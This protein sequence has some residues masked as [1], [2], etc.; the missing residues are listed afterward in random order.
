M[1]LKTACLIAIFFSLFGID[2]HFI[3]ETK[4]LNKIYKV[5]ER[6]P[7][8]GWIFYDKGNKTG[9]WQYLEAAPSDYNDFT[10]WGCVGTSP[11]PDAHGIA[12]GTGKNNTQA[13]VNSC[14]WR[15]KY[16]RQSMYK[17]SWWR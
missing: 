2:N 14:L 15:S 5:G 11:M 10:E 3:S 1:R 12:I 16:C 8:G 13:I 4:A 6:G 9:G 17:I 7:A